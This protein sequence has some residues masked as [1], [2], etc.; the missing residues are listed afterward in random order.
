MRKSELLQVRV[1]P[2]DKIA[3]R[4]AQSHG[5]WVSLSDMVRAMVAQYAARHPDSGQH[6]PAPLDEAPQL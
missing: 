5:G 3:F 6:Q 1:S 4:A 2:E